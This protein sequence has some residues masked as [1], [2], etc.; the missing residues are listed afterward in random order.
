ML[1]QY[2]K[3]LLFDS[4]TF[5]SCRSETA[6]KSLSFSQVYG[7]LFPRLNGKL[8]DVCV[9]EEGSVVVRAGGD[10]RAGM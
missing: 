1:V 5:Q 7:T 6:P 8:E 3:N 2:T 4:E 10:K 9:V